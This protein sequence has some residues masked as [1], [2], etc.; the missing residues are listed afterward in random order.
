[1]GDQAT[2]S[3]SLQA[4][5]LAPGT[6]ELLHARLA[7]LEQV[8][9]A[10]DDAAR[11]DLFG[12]HLVGRSPNMIRMYRAAFA[13]LRTVLAGIDERLDVSLAEEPRL[14]QVVSFGL[15]EAFGRW[16]LARG[17]A[18]KSVNHYMCV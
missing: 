2:S 13:A 15:V 9:R 1:M 5:E 17:Y 6:D 8:S 3:R 7:L 10:A 4:V 12:R 14:W 18:I 16:L 11:R